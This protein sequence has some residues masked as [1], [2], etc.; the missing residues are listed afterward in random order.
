MTEQSIGSD[1]FAV[2]GILVLER[3]AGGQFRKIGPAPA[4]YS[5]P[6]PDAEADPRR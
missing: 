2:L 4:W 3:E 5:G 6:C 1:V